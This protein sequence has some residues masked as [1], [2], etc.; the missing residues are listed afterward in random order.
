LSAAHTDSQLK[1]KDA[2]KN[3][4]LQCR[5]FHVSIIEYPKQVS[6][7]KCRNVNCICP[8]AVTIDISATI[9]MQ[10]HYTEIELIEI[11]AETDKLNEIKKQLH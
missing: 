7:F 11:K 9:L 4:I 5:D 10:T 2:P 8:S 3:I 1:M 6:D